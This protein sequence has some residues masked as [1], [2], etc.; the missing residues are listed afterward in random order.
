MEVEHRSESSDVGSW[1]A[2]EQPKDVPE[3]SQLRQRQAMTPSAQGRSAGRGK[4]VVRLVEAQR[5]GLHHGGRRRHY[6]SL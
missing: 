6:S 3:P 5:L 2:R 4:R 1:H